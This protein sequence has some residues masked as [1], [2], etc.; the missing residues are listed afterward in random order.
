MDCEVARELIERQ[1]DEPLSAVRAKALGEHLSRCRACSAFGEESQR[2]VQELGALAPPETDDARW[3]E[4]VGGAVAEGSARLRAWRDGRAVRRLV[5]AAAAVWLVAWFFAHRAEVRSG[6]LGP[7]TGGPA[8]LQ[9]GTPVDSD[10]FE[11]LE[12]VVGI[13]AAR[14][15][16]TRPIEPGPLRLLRPA[17]LEHLAATGELPEPPEPE[18]EPPA[19]AESQSRSQGPPAGD[20]RAEERSHV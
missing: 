5:L 18:A 3:D 20:P 7:G 1:L 12:G 15:L 6:S 2:L 19:E 4:L 17:M 13:G 8:G 9:A 10:Q 16:P 11:E 14:L